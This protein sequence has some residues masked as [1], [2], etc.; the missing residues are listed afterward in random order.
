MDVGWPRTAGGGLEIHDPVLIFALAMALMLVAPMLFRR[1]RL[2][3]IVGLILAGFMVGPHGFGFLTRDGTFELLGTVGIIFLM[4]LAGLEVNPQQFRRQ[5]GPTLLF[6]VLT[7]ALPQITGTL[8]A[9]ALLGF[10]WPAAVL[11]GSLFASHTLLPY[12]IVSQLGLG[13]NRAVSTAIGGTIM[14]DTAALLVLAVVA[15]TTVR[16][17]SGAFLFRQMILL[18]LLVVAVLWGLR[19]ASYWFFRHVTPDGV[20]EFLFVVAAVFLSAHLASLAG[21]EPIIGAFLAGLSLS[22]LIPD[23]SPLHNRL[24]FI[25]QAIFIPFFL[26]SVGMLINL[27][28]FMTGLRGLGVAVMMTLAVTATKWAAAWLS[29]RT[30]KYSEDEIRLLFG[31]TV[32]QAAATLAAVLVGYRIG[33]LDA[34]VLNGSIIMM[35]V[36]CVLGPSVA[37][38]AARRMVLAQKHVMPEPAD[39]HGRVLV[40]LSNDKTADLLTDL[41]LMLREGASSEPVHLLTVIPDG[42]D[43]EAGLA[44]ADRLLGKAVVR[45]TA[46]GVP[47]TPVSRIEA[48]VAGGIIKSLAELRI[49]TVVMGWDARSTAQRYIFHSI[50]DQVLA[51]SRQMMALARIVAPLNTTQRLVAVVPH[52]AEAHPGFGAVTG[53]LWRLAAEMGAKVLIAAAAET[54]AALQR[55]AETG[56]RPVS[57]D[58]LALGPSTDLARAL[59]SALEPGDT[60]VVCCVRPGRPGWQPRWERLPA[61]LARDLSGHTLLAVYP[62]EPGILEPAP[63]V[64]ALP[65][66][67]A[68]SRVAI[69]L[70]AKDLDGVV[71]RLLPT[72]LPPRARWVSALRAQLAGLEPIE[73][74]PGAVLLHAHIGQ[75]AEPLIFVGTAARGI[76]AEPL[77]KDVRVVF[78]LLS[79]EDQAPEHHLES[80]A[81]IA[82]MTRRPDFADAVAAC[83]APGEVLALLASTGTGTPRA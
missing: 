75:I 4:F 2:P 54:A 70:D 83:R 73:L 46:A 76:R 37:E 44:A 72:A 9:R 41:A 59:R 33:L 53:L 81:H 61:Q 13:R 52:G 56:R 22:P 32:N 26:L 10:G 17:L 51:R 29:G 27:D 80:L 74:V 71:R 65:P 38:A 16:G 40:P 35:L 6:G 66:G 30:L 67:F 8:L 60:V 19:R 42:P 45:A 14:T 36:T 78:I 15:E 68:D 63:S 34:S 58:T 49:S 62:R 12:P 5:S 47:V 64:A 1:L 39:A 20:T 23:S 77:K 55:Q 48:N 7:F 11:L 57:A 18:G 82:R 3:G 50:S 24:G 43:V 69:G 25:G 79:P 21:V 31:L 28:V